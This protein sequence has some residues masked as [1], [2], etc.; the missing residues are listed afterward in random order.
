MRAHPPRVG[1]RSI[2]PSRQSSETEPKVPVPTASTTTKSESAD[3]GSPKQ[4]LMPTRLPHLPLRSGTNLLQ[5]RLATVD[6]LKADDLLRL[7][8]VASELNV[9]IFNLP[10]KFGVQASAP[11]W[12]RGENEGIP[13]LLGT[14]V[15][16]TVKQHETDD[17]T[18]KALE[19]GTIVAL[20]RYTHDTSADDLIADK[21][22]AEVILQ[23]LRVLCHPRLRSHENFCR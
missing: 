9:P 8:L 12:N 4:S 5:S 18:A 19:P 13:Y 6:Y 7:R 23:D 3:A 16:C 22:M 17:S 10:E 2:Q 11:R 15:S 20:K 1:P 14:G 21:R